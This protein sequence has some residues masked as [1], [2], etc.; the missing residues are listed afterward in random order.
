MF[1]RVSDGTLCNDASSTMNLV[2]TFMI[3]KPLL[4]EEIHSKI[5]FSSYI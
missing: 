1:E 5:L 2:E 3:Y 4:S